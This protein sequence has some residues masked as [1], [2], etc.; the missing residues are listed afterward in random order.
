M[1]S[2]QL[3]SHQNHVAPQSAGEIK[4]RALWWIPTGARAQSAK[5]CSCTWRIYLTLRHVVQKQTHAGVRCAH[6]HTRLSADKWPAAGAGRI[7]CVRSAATATPAQF[8]IARAIMYSAPLTLQH[9]SSVTG[10][11]PACG[12]TANITCHQTW[13]DKQ[14]HCFLFALLRSRCRC[15]RFHLEATRPPWALQISLSASILCTFAYVMA[16]EQIKFLLPATQLGV[17]AFEITNAAMRTWLFGSRQ[18]MVA[19]HF[20][21]VTFVQ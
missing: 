19:R 12:T 3:I 21:I 6:S 14:I 18:I 4:D 7:K 1:H 17:F 15:S 9:L 20:L 16:S 11:S 5:S 8:C 2:P 10:W 13:L